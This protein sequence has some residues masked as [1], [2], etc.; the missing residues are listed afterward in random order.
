MA[1]NKLYGTN[2]GWAA[3]RQV[4]VD[5]AAL[6]YGIPYHVIVPIVTTKEWSNML[7]WCVE[8]FGPSGMTSFPDQRWYVRNG[9]F[10]LKQD[11][12]RDWFM[13]RWS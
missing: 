6:V 1:N 13:L 10:L 9:K 3:A 7:E 8:T 11:A 4:F 5:S 12:D 2:G